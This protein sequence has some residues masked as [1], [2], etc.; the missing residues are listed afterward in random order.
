MNR[1]RSS[2]TPTAKTRV[3]LVDDDDFLRTSVWELLTE[4]GYRV[5]F[6]EDG[7]A[8]LLQIR[9]EIPDIIISDLNTPAMSG[10]AFL[11]IL[12]RR[13][14]HI[15]VI[16]MSAAVS[17]DGVPPPGIAADHFYAKGSNLNALMKMVKFMS[18][19]ER[20]C[21]LRHSFE[22][23]PLWIPG[24]SYD[25][26][27]DAYVMITCPACLRIFPQVFVEGIYPVY[28]TGCVFC[29]SLIHYAIVQP[30]DSIASRAPQRKAGALIAMPL[31]ARHLG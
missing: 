19:P 1:N 6:A 16:A 12:R 22:L 29:H 8:A 10:V 24:N 28:E 23:T 2:P 15:R 27:G 5:R 14:P 4:A 7:F 25:P 18:Y 26:S 20:D 31:R 17:N 13:F 30:T 11:S 3:L 9:E 21:H